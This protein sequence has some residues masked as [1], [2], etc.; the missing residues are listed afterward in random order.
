[1]GTHKGLDEMI[2]ITHVDAHLER[3]YGDGVSHAVVSRDAG[4]VLK[5]YKEVL[6]KKKDLTWYALSTARLRWEM[7]CATHTVGPE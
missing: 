7:R 1:M 3:S 6:Q 2:V 4:T 5:S